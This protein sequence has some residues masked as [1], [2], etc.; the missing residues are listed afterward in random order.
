MEDKI[1]EE[2]KTL[3][4]SDMK[5]KYISAGIYPE[6]FDVP[7][8]HMKP[9]VQC[10]VIAHAKKMYPTDILFCHTAGLDIEGIRVAASCLP[11]D[12]YSELIV[13][14]RQDLFQ[15]VKEQIEKEAQALADQQNALNRLHNIAQTLQ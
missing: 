8:E 6:N 11:I 9:V 7:F 4:L 13:V 2:K 5:D 10:F 12:Q 3:V 15:R 14:L 1:I